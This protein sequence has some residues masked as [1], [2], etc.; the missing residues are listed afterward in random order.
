[1]NVVRGSTSNETKMIKGIQ[2]AVGALQDGLIGEQTMSDIA[3]LLKA[4]CFPLTLRIY[5]MPAIIAKDIL[6]FASGG[7]PLSAY[8]N[9]I[10]GSF[11]VEQKIGGPFPVSVLISNGKVVRGVSCHHPE[12]YPES[13]IYRLEDGTFGIRRAKQVEELPANIRWAVGG[14]GLLDFY[15]PQGEGFVG[16]YAGVLRRTNHSVLGVKNNHIYLVYCKN[17]SAAEV[18]AFAKQLGLEMAIMMD[19]GH[20]AGI[21]GAESFAK[22]NTSMRQ[23][24]IVQ[25]I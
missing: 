1:M 20:V 6:P 13:V 10:N 22:I 8:A 2:A 5:Q 19:G 25:A 23:A 18:N 24:Y 21:N 17:K 7:K 4:D 3:C 14:L 16:N 12:G 15:D 11:F 9:C